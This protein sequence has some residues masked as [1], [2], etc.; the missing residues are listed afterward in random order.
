MLQESRPSSHLRYFVLFPSSFTINDIC[1]DHYFRVVAVVSEYRACDNWPESPP[2]LEV[3]TDIEN[4]EGAGVTAM[5][6]NHSPH[7]ADDF[8]GHR[9]C[10][11]GDKVWL[12]K[13]V[14]F[15]HR[16]SD[17]TYAFRY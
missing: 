11:W 14:E 17:G 9:L 1:P 12:T 10:L 15:S 6:L 7:P 13:E 4:P 8:E 2:F 16:F 5:M 3:A